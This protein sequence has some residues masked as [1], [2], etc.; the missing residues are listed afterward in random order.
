[1]K[2]YT[3]PT[4]TELEFCTEV[5]ALSIQKGNASTEFGVLT[6]RKGWSSEDWSGT[7]EE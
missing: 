1:M 3:K 6:N 2:K 5:L 4:S 7:P